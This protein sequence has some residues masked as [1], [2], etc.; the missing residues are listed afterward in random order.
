M[1]WTWSYLNIIEIGVMTLRSN[2]IIDIDGRVCFIATEDGSNVL[3][4]NY[5]IRRNR[6]KQ[7]PIINSSDNITFGLAAEIDTTIKFGRLTYSFSP[8]ISNVDG[9]DWNVDIFV[10]ILSSQSFLSLK[11]RN[12]H[13]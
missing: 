12:F 13:C 4:K 3:L 8:D 7:H 5:P 10:K 1:G 11:L 9:I 2:N 6:F